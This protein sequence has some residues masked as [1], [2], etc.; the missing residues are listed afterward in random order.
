MTESDDKKAAKPEGIDQNAP[1]LG[2]PTFATVAMAVGAGYILI[3]FLFGL[4]GVVFAVPAG[5]TVL[6]GLVS[7][8]V[9][10]AQKRNRRGPYRR[11]HIAVFVVSLAL[12]AFLLPGLGTIR[13][14]NLH[15]RMRVAVT[16]GQEELQAWAMEVLARPRDPMQEDG[17]G[18]R[19]PREEC[20]RQVRRLNPKRIRI[21][22]SYG[23]DREIVRLMYG[24]GFF[25]WNIGIGPPDAIGD[26]A[27][28][29][30]VADCVW[31]RWC[32]GICCWF[33][34]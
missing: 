27:V 19:I 15:C 34:N 33:P 1:A 9:G 13:T 7:A 30:K 4:I 18:W 28:K 20:S 11:R 17:S 6:A 29:A 10:L 25:H 8:S 2:P 14:L 16:G 24:G 12:A 26:L 22:R 3:L 5:L 31:F 23:N 21:E 32:D